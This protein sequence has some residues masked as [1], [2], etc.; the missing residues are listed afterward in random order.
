MEPIECPFCK[1]LFCLQHKIESDHKCKAK[2]KQT[3]S[4]IYA[5]KR[6]LARKK[7]EEAKRKLGKK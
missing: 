6:E 5:E 3:I 1:G 2:V 7:I 4:D